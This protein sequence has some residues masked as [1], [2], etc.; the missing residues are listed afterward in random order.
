MDR[1]SWKRK[2]IAYDEN[3]EPSKAKKDKRRGQNHARGAPRDA[4]SSCPS[5][6]EWKKALLQCVS[7]TTP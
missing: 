3:K 7:N 4:R 1:A 2:D 5:H 6:S